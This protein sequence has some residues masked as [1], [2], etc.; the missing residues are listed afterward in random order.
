MIRLP[1]SV[2]IIGYNEEKKI[3]DCLESVSDIVDEIVFVD[4][5]STDSTVSI[6][7]EYTTKIY[8]RD[9]NSYTDQKNYAQS[10]CKNEWVLNLDCDERLSPEA[11]EELL[12]KF[13]SIQENPEIV[14]ISFPRL[15][16]YLYKFLRH[17]GWY[18]DR[19]IRLVRKCCCAWEGK[20]L[21]EEM[22]CKGNI[23]PFQGD[24][25]HYSF[26]SVDDHLKTIMK[27]SEMGAQDLWD[28][29]RRSSLC[30]MVART[31]WTGFRKIFLEFAFLDGV[32]GI[33]MTGFS[34]AATWSKY[35]KLYL[36]QKKQILNQK[37]NSAV[38]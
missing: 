3:K 22:K 32:A 11:R 5:H 35:S 13:P 16:F 28:K 38:Q 12:N 25:L 21:H 26:D 7:R 24:I 14:G 34:M 4:S 29:G 10:L 27:F 2:Y 19:K 1:I 20:R 36:L 8:T 15:T 6:V 23:V 9:F 17:G 18:P 37:G 31:F 30:T 33:I